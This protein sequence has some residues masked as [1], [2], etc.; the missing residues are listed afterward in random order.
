VSRGFDARPTALIAGAI[1]ITG[2]IGV[3]VGIVIEPRRALA[4][5][6]AA[7]TACATTAIGALALLAIGY[8]ANAK[9]PAAVRRID[10]A[11]AAAIAPLALLFGPILLFSDD[12]WPRGPHVVWRTPLA[13]A[14]RSIVYLTIFIV[15]AELLR[16]WS[17]RRDAAPA[18]TLDRERRFASAMLPPIGVALTFA[19]FDW[20]MAVQPLWESSVFGL[21]VTAGA[22]V[23]GLALTAAL[24]MRG[25][26]T[27]AIPLTP[28]HFHAMGRLLLAFVALWAY[29][30]F[31][32]AFLIQ[33]ANRPD[34]VTFYI[35]RMTGSWRVVTVAV[36]ALGFA[37]PLP[38]LVPR[39]LKLRPRYV[40]TIAAMLLVGHYLD[41]WWLVIP[42]FD[43]AVPSWTDLV[44]GCAVI[45]L[46]T[47]AAAWRAHRVPLL[48]A[49]DPSLADGFAYTSPP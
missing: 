24:G 7:W 30:A 48:P 32:Q 9:W 20:L 6:L 35:T 37:L 13:I 12:V 17:I 26:G 22:L 45:G 23:G 29:I 34:E 15:P 44:A 3:A 10:E 1:G 42:A 25:V 5:Y 16:R 28:Y 27:R 41:V 39:R 11:I 43:S 14:M 36:V 8:A 46:T 38:L 31:F 33:I 18:A 40:G 47:A 49:G 2:W 4:A 21:Y 19:A